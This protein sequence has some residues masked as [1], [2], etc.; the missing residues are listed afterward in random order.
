MKTNYKKNKYGSR[1]GKKVFSRKEKKH[2]KKIEIEE[3]VNHDLLAGIKINVDNEVTDFSV[4][5]KLSTMKEQIT[6]NR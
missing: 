3:V 6:I 4:R 1:K 2:N 5:F